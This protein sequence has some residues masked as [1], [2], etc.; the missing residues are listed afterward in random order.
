MQCCTDSVCDPCKRVSP[1]KDQ[2]QHNELRSSHLLHQPRGQPLPAAGLDPNDPNNQLVALAAGLPLGPFPATPTT[3]FNKCFVCLAVRCLELFGAPNNACPT[4]ETVLV[5]VLD[6]CDDPRCN[7]LAADG[8]YNLDFAD[9]TFRRVF[10]SD[11]PNRGPGEG[12]VEWRVTDCGWISTSIT[13]R[14]VNLES[15]FVRFSFQRVAGVPGRVTRAFVRPQGASDFVQLTDSSQLNADERG[16]QDA[17]FFIAKYVGVLML[18]TTSKA[19][20]TQ[21]RGPAL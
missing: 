4:Q 21:P 16:D 8:V 2:L 14:L 6:Q 10:G 5:R 15:F 17:V 13:A 7:G 19:H 18:H 3:T 20:S 12:R 1:C 11:V 9:Y